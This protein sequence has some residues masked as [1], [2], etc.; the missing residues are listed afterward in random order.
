MSKKKKKNFLFRLLNHM[1]ILFLNGLLTILPITFTIVIFTVAFKLISGWLEPLREVEWLKPLRKIEPTFLKEIPHVTEIILAIII[2]FLIGTIIK[3]FVFKQIVHSFENLIAKIPI[4]RPIYK[5]TK[6]LVQA[7][8]MK[9]KI[10]FKQV[11]MI[12]FPRKDMYC[13]GFLTSQL[14]IEIS[15]DQEKRFF[16]I[17]VPTTPNPTSGYFIILPEKDIKRIAITRQEAMAMIISGGII[18]PDRFASPEE[19]K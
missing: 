8:G 14:P 10:S 15:P 3:I 2:I 5:G 19:K 13:I 6:Q 12:E 17:F 16:N 7:F 4:I 11:V 9:D 1:W 18:Q